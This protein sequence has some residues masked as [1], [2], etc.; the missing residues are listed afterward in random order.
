[1]KLYTGFYGKRFKRVVGKLSKNGKIL[2]DVLAVIPMPTEEGYFV[3][4]LQHL[5]STA[6]AIDSNGERIVI[7]VR[8]KD[9]EDFRCLDHY[10]PGNM[11]LIYEQYKK[12]MVTDFESYKDE[13]TI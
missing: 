7:N 5:D 10:H 9:L 13:E 8:V 11:K 12:W 1:M 6:F 3:S 2:E 4:L